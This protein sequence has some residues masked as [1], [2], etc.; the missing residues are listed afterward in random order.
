MSDETLKG[1]AEQWAQDLSRIPL[2]RLYEITEPVIL[3]ATTFPPQ[4]ADFGAKWDA[5]HAAE[6]Q[7]YNAEAW[8]REDDAKREQ[9][10]PV[11]AG[12]FAGGAD[13]SQA[14]VF[15]KSFQAFGEGVCCDCKG[16]RFGGIAA[17]L[18]RSSEFW[19]CA[20][21]LCAYQ[22][23]ARS[24]KLP[25]APAPKTAPDSDDITSAAPKREYS[26]EEILQELD[27]RTEF[28]DTFSDRRALG[29]ARFMATRC[30]VDLWT[31]RM[32]KI[33]W[34]KYQDYLRTQNVA[35]API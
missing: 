16:D 21:G 9:M 27:T 12:S 6:V 35:H 3:A 15:V 34:P 23:S 26:D 17:K 1:I 20:K 32:A 22:Q 25:A 11:P 8:K 13:T 10:A 14:P 30:P 33:N 2:N 29:F 5:I 4:G 31:V 18:D 7:I 28:K 24:L 19:I